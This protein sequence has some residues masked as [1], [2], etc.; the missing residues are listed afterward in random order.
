MMPYVHHVAKEKKTAKI[1][2]RAPVEFAPII[3]DKPVVPKTVAVKT[4][5][6]SAKTKA[7]LEHTITDLKSAFLLDLILTHCQPAF[8][9]LA[10]VAVKK[11]IK[12]GALGVAGGPGITV[13][14]KYRASHRRR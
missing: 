7:V 6:G 1:E 8:K 5:H 9:T 2:R 14:E 12:A 3:V 13:E 11:A 10:D 4:A